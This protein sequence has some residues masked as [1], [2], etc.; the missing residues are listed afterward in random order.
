MIQYFPFPFP[1]FPFLSPFPFPFI[2]SLFP[3]NDLYLPTFYIP[4]P[5]FKVNHL[6]HPSAS[7]SLPILPMLQLYY[8]NATLYINVPLPFL[9]LTFLTRFKHTGHVSPNDYVTCIHLFPT[10]LKHLHFFFL[11]FFFFF[12]FYYLLHL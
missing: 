5:L 4:R 6:V 2:S 9:P 7:P 3:F 1:F 12:F 10:I 8:P 11:S